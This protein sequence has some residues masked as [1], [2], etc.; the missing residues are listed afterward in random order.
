[1]DSSTSK[2]KNSSS[3]NASFG[4]QPPKK[5]L[6]LKLFG[7]CNFGGMIETIIKQPDSNLKQ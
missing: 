3:V 2:E 6:N 7:T 5:N 4:I 1:L